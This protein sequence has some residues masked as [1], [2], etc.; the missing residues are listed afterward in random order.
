VG[1]DLDI[2]QIEKRLLTKRNLLLVEGMGGAGK[3]TLLQ[4]LGGWW[5]QTNLVSQV[6]YFSYDERPWT[7]QQIMDTIA[8]QLFSQT[9]YYGTFQ[10]MGL[11]AQQAYLGQRLRAGRHLLILDNLESITG[12]EL[13]IQHTLPTEE[14]DALR[15]LLAE[16]VGGRTLVLL[17]SRGRE[18]WLAPDTFG[19]NVYA[20]AGL[21][22]EAASVLTERIL[23]RLR[24]DRQLT[25]QQ[26]TAYRQDASFRDLLA[27][28]DGFPLAL[29]VVLSTLG[30]QPPAEV[31]AALREGQIS[32][33][34]S[35]SQERTKSIVQCVDYAHRQLPPEVQQLLLCLAP[36]TGVMNL[37]FLEQYTRRL[38]EQ[39]TLAALLFAQWEQLLETSA[40]WRLVRPG[41]TP[42][43]LR[44]HP[45]LP[46]FLR[47]RLAAPEQQEARRAIETAF[48]RHYAN[49]AAA[50]Y[51]LLE[52][53][54][55]QERQLGQALAHLEYE[56]V[57][58]ALDLALTARQSILAYYSV[59]SRYLEARQDQQRGLE[60]AG[61]VKAR[62]EEYPA[63]AL[64]GPLG[65]E[66]VGVL[67]NLAKWQ[68]LLKRHDEAR[69]SYQDALDRWLA[70]QSFSEAER[71]QGSASILHQLGMVAQEQ[72]Q[73]EQAEQYYQQALEIKKEF[74]ARYEQAGTLHQLGRVAQEQRQ[75]EQAREAFLQA[76]E[77]Y[78]DF[79]EIYNGQIVMGSLA[80]LWHASQDAS[81]PAAVAAL[82]GVQ[83]DDVEADWRRWLEGTAPAAEEAPAAGP[84]PSPS[85]AA[86]TPASPQPP[87]A[88]S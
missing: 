87:P 79:Q 29:E 80:R 19:E 55:P 36:F 44:L 1:R 33:A 39:P 61:Q 70:N 56:N 72:R 76:L 9:E 65:L 12:A 48:C 15:R 7:R 4:H 18:D 22:P 16:L 69:A 23:D 73:W 77:I 25:R 42:D 30:R 75:W 32:L 40:R 83:P 46:F 49:L 85:P 5:Q 13:A 37:R 52:S 59:L 78:V 17:G 54:D 63:E 84:A 67:D 66:L 6:F 38:K 45:I 60:L 14:R 51:N 50:L 81:L 41:E 64:S 86:D 34:D 2:L 20:L 35:D 71:R 57:H 10:P 58:H 28:L 27:L 24:E 21:D 88:R 8:R 43:F 53:K 11:D 68:L 31:L 82:F 62:L 26:I 3:T 74:N 47:S